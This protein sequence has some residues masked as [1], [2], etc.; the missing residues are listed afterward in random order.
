M[1]TFLFAAVAIVASLGCASGAAPADE[2]ALRK[3]EGRVLTSAEKP[4]ARLE[5]AEGFK[6]AGGQKFI[7]YD[8]AHAEQHFFVDAGADG[9][10]KR[11]YWVQFEGYLPDNTHAYD[12][13]SPTKV[14]IGGLEFVADAFPVS[15]AGPEQRPDSDGARARALLAAKGYTMAGSELMMQ[16]LV[17][18]LDATKRDELMIIYI[19]SLDGTGLDAESLEPGGRAAGRW[20]ELSK[21]LLERATR[22]VRITR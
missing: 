7:L 4:A 22:G 12:Y 15:T 5:F 11:L 13:D 18:L 20:A 21:G 3:V 17:H 19:E 9:K 2:R 1:R 10:V 6:Y 14:E 16:R 8:V